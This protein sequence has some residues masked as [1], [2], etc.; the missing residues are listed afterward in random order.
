MNE[1][2]RENVKFFNLKITREIVKLRSISICKIV[3]IENFKHT[4]FNFK[5]SKCFFFHERVNPKMHSGQKS[6]RPV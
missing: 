4:K 1:K 5:N 6:R 3:S 2:D